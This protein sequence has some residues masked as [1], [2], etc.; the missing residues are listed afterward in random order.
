[1]APFTEVISQGIALVEN[2]VKKK[3]FRRAVLEAQRPLTG[4]LDV[5][6]ADSDDLQDI[7]IQ[8][9]ER[10][11]DPYR[12]QVDSCGSRFQ[13][14]LKE[15]RLTDGLEA[16]LAR[17]NQIR[18]RMRRS[19]VKQITYQPTGSV[20]DPTSADMEAMTLLVDQAELNVINYNYVEGKILAQISVFEEYRNVLGV[21]KQAFMAL[22][23]AINAAQFAATNSF[24]KQARDLRKAILKLQEA[25]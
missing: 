20:A 2:A 13:R 12:K 25:K 16:L 21:T 17:H 1:M 19:G 6:I 9:L 15:F 18:T 11:Q 14:R 7:F 23:A 22:P 5:L 3:K 8:E 4:I 24:I 10:A